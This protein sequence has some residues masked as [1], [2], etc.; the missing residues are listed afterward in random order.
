M[1]I[2]DET[3]QE[4]S[5]WRM[6]PEQRAGETDAQFLS[7]QINIDGERYEFNGREFQVK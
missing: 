6:S 4:P 5:E 7:R 2:A 3:K 1:Q